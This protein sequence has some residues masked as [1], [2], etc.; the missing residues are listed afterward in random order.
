MGETADPKEEQIKAAEATYEHVRMLWDNQ[1]DCAK[2]LTEKRKN[3]SAMMAILLGLGLFRLQLFRR[4]DE[5]LAV[6][7]WA[8]SCVLASSVLAMLAFTIGG[9]LL[10]T[11]RP[12]CRRSMLWLYWEARRWV[13]YLIKLARANKDSP[14]A[15]LGPH[16]PTLWPAGRVLDLTLPDDEDLNDWFLQP[17][18]VVIQTRTQ[19]LRNAYITLR[20]RNNRVAKRL[21]EA[22]F[23][24]FAG[25]FMVFVALGMYL[26]AVGGWFK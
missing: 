23:F 21:R 14:A 1:V 22:L 24:L 8:A 9:Y 18:L 26:L 17:P 16:P 3:L 5:V 7:G 13:A 11:Q 2:D 6:P 12:N 15:T 25:F 19:R 10:Y 20:A 4:Q